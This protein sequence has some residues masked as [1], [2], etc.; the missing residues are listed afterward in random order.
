MIGAPRLRNGLPLDYKLITPFASV[1]GP[2]FGWPLLVSSSLTGSCKFKLE[3]L[4]YLYDSPLD[5]LVWPSALGAAGRLR[6][7]LL[8]SEGLQCELSFT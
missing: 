2:A 6:A 3:V 8:F 1:D 7:A 4:S 5:R